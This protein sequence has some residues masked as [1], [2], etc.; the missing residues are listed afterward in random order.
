MPGCLMQDAVPENAELVTGF[1]RLRPVIHDWLG[2]DL[3]GPPLDYTRAYTDLMFAFGF[4]RLGASDE[5]KEA[6]RTAM[7]VLEA[8]AEF[9]TTPPG[10]LAADWDRWIASS[11]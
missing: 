3:A 10:N 6:S 7:L 1:R 8:D 11:L 2:R 9:R 4:A 5:A